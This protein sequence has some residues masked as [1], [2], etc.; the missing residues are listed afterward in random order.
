MVLQFLYV[1]E[2][3]IPQGWRVNN[4]P[5]E[6]PGSLCKGYQVGIPE[7]KDIPEENEKEEDQSNKEEDKLRAIRS[8]N[9]DK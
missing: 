8:E 5:G 7:R 4:Q 6:A 3:Y 1:K 9:I 2:V